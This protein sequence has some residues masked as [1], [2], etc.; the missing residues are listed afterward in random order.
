MADDPNPFDPIEPVPG[1]L[2]DGTAPRGPHGGEPAFESDGEDGSGAM[3]P[4]GEDSGASQS[5]RV[6]IGTGRSGIDAPSDA[7]P[8]PSGS[9]A[10]PR[11]LEDIERGGEIGR[12]HV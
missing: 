12:A 10:S 3:E 11:F 2:P 1:A 7:L 8:E 5:S 4:D 9:G 6:L